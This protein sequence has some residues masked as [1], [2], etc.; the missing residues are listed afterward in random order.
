[1]SR[2]RFALSALA[3]MLLAVPSLQAVE[4]QSVAGTDTKL[5]VYGFVRVDATYFADSLQ[6]FAGTTAQ[7]FAAVG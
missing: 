1:M 7:G 5:K 2:S 3:A 6:N 4:L